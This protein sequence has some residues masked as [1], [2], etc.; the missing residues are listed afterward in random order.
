MNYFEIRVFITKKKLYS[1]QATCKLRPQAV[2][3]TV[4]RFK[5]NFSLSLSKSIFGL[6]LGFKQTLKDNLSSF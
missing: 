1:S 6:L 2:K 5:R 4:L 3:L